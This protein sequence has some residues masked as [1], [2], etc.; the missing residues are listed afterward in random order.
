MLTDLRQLVVIHFLML[1]VVLLL[2]LRLLGWLSMIEVVVVNI[3]VLSHVPSMLALFPRLF[4]HAFVD[5]VEVSTQLVNIFHLVLCTFG[6]MRHW[7][8]KK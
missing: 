3:V 6:N 1:V 7:F 2:L 8:E 5:K 4:I